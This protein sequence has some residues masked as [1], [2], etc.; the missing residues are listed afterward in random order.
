MKRHE[1]EQRFREIVKRDTKLDAQEHLALLDQYLY[2]WDGADCGLCGE[3][4][5]NRLSR[6]AGVLDYLDFMDKIKTDEA[7][8]ML[9]NEIEAFAYKVAEDWSNSSWSAEKAVQ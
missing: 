7:L 5:Q 8:W 4:L 1:M 3:E 2:A 9:M 6:I